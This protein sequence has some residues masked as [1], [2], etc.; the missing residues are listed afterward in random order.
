MVTTDN[1]E[2]IFDIV[3]AC[4]RV[5]G[6]AT[7]GECNTNPALIHRAV[8]I[9]IYNDRNEVLWQKRSLTKDTAP[10][11][12]VTSASGHVNAGDDYE[13]TA[14][15]EVTE[16]LGI[17]VPLEFAGKFFYRYRK[18]N[19]FSAVFRGR[20]NGPFHFNRDEISAVRFMT[21]AEI[22]KKDKEKELKLSRAA[23]NIIDS[24]SLY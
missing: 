3:D 17:D 6:Q 18:E 10:G 15:R 9:L 13:E 2:E 4:D 20:S 24:L 22:L 21:V 1:L 11:Q 16:E 12:W 7:R 19:E 14:R 8:F 5:I 23:H